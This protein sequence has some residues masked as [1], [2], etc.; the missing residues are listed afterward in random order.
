MDHVT[1]M[2]EYTLILVYIF[3][4]TNNLKL[5]LNNHGNHYML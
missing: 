5:L 2:S 3:I 1:Y 4:K